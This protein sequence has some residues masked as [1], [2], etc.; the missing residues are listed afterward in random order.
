MKSLLLAATL[1]AAAP[2]YAEDFSDPTVPV[3]ALQVKQCMA[4]IKPNDKD[5]IDTACDEM[6]FSSNGRTNNVHFYGNDVRMTYIMDAKAHGEVHAVAFILGDGEPVALPA[7]GNCKTNRENII[8]GAAT[9]YGG[10]VNGAV[11]YTG[12][13]Q[14]KNLTR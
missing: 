9:E 13:P 5:W 2:A 12:L 10:F 6:A 14:L 4:S 11:P 1:L 7:S 8:C 3:I